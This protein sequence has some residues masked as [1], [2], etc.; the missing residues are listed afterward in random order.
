MSIFSNKII[1]AVEKTFNIQIIKEYNLGQFISG[2]TRNKIRKADLFIKTDQIY[3]L[4]KNTIIEIQGSQHYDKNSARVLFRNHPKWKDKFYDLVLRDRWEEK[5][6]QQKDIL[7]IR[8][9][10]IIWTGNNKDYIDNITVLC[11]LIKSPGYLDYILREAHNRNA[12]G[13]EIDQT[14]NPTFYNKRKMKSPKL[15][16]DKNYEKTQNR[17]RFR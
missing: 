15:P 9:L 16:I 3:G 1:D 8:F 4:T 13:V 7:L 11:N 14:G 6:L 17:F 5:I 12:H 10:P 2:Y